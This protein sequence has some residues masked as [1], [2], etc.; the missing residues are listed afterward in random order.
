MWKSGSACERMSKIKIWYT[1][2]IYTTSPSLVWP[3]DLGRFRGTNARWNFDSKKR[4]LGLG[5]SQ[6]HL[7]IYIYTHTHVTFQDFTQHPRCFN[8]LSRSNYSFLVGPLKLNV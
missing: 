2:F 3:E 1:S 4:E 8:V 7:R 5:T 6:T